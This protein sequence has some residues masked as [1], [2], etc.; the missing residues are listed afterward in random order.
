MD[1]RSTKLGFD[2]VEKQI[3]VYWYK[4]FLKNHI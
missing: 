3:Q 2:F 4:F 1:E